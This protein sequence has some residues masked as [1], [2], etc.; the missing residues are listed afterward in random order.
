M[1]VLHKVEVNRAMSLIHYLEAALLQKMCIV[2][3]KWSAQLFLGGFI[4]EMQV[5][6]VDIIALLIVLLACLLI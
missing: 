3:V 2:G 5:E 4:M 1:F 6:I